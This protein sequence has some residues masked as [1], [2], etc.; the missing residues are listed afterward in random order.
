MAVRVQSN[1]DARVSEHLD[2]YLRVHALRQEQC[3]AGVSQVV[4]P[5]VRQPGMPQQ[6]LPTSGVQIVTPDRGASP[7]AEQ[8]IAGLVLPSTITSALGLLALPVSL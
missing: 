8:E 7:R 4:E 6:R 2:H 1:A 3:R 5:Y